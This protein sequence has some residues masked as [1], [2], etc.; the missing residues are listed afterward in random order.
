MPRR[1]CRTPDELLLLDIM[2]YVDDTTCHQLFR[3]RR[4]GRHVGGGGVSFEGFWTF[5]FL[6]AHER[7]RSEFGLKAAKAFGINDRPI[8]EAAFFVMNGRHVGAELLENDV[9]HA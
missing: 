4:V 9:A 7:I 2:E 6:N 1:A 3:L 5:P 8:F